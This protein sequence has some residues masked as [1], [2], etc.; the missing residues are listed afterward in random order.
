M[1]GF[2]DTVLP[3]LENAL[4]AGHDIIFLGE[5][6]QAKTRMIRSLTALLDEYLPIVGGSEINDDP[7]NPV[8]YALDRAEELGE[9]TPIDLGAPLT[10]LRREAGHA[11]HLHRRPPRRGGPHQDRRGPLPERRELALHYGLILRANRGL[12]AGH[13]RAAGPLG[14]GIQVGLLNILEERDVQIRG[15]ASGCRSTSRLVA[16]A[17]PGGLHEP[18]AGSSRRSRTGFGAQ[19]RTHYLYETTTEVRIMEG[20]ADLADGGRAGD[21]AA[22]S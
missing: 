16:T 11:G 20:E 18:L 3:Q 12:F 6:G 2:E 22:D 13:Q 17:N 1:L 5:R 7:Y 9:A 8:C 21:G 15:I 14:A 19:I 10:A 4:L